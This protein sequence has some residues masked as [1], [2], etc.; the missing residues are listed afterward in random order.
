M[1]V[2]IV[3]FTILVILNVKINCARN[4]ENVLCFVKVMPKILAVPFLPDTEYIWFYYGIM[5]HFTLLNFTA[6]FF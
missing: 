6:M 5:A 3:H 4:Y 1:Q 2:V